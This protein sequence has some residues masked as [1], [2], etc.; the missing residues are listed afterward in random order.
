[1]NDYSLMGEDMMVKKGAV[2]LHFK[3]KVWVAKMELNE[4]DRIVFFFFF[5]FFFCQ[6][7]SCEGLGTLNFI[8]IGSS[9]KWK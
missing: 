8:S 5:F 4:R 6:G 7:P 1:M 3:G 2:G 9:G